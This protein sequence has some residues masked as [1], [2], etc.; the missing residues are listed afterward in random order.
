M[1]EAFEHVP[2]IP[3]RLIQ[4]VPRLDPVWFQRFAAFRTP[5]LADQVGLHYTMDPGIRP[6][7]E[8]MEPMVGQALT[9]KP[10][11][12][13]GLAM[14]GAASLAQSGDV[15][16]VDG[17]GQLEISRGGFHVLSLPRKRGAA[18]AVIDGAIRDATEFQEVGFP[19]FARSRTPHASSKRR[20]GEINVP[21][22]CGGVIVEPG[23]LVV[24]DSEGVVVIPRAHISLVWEAVSGERH[25]G[26]TDDQIEM[27]AS[28]RW[29][30][31]E[32]A[33]KAAGGVA[34]D[35]TDPAAESS[36]PGKLDQ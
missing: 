5:D 14:F 15:L 32:R 6:L 2:V 27:N 3:P 7:Y 23:D 20:P 17:R 24:G 4:N 30:N 33:F 21:V 26:Q 35:W 13:D 19:L 18:G 16:V 8:P 34:A 28:K 9:V 25:L 29:A 22:S 10:W 36:G 1:D 12:G 11:P 31:Y